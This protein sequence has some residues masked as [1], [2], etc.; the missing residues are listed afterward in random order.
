MH[1][2]KGL[3][4]QGADK[5]WALVLVQERGCRS[6]R[7]QPA[8][9]CSSLLSAAVVLVPKCHMQMF[10]RH[11]DLQ[12]WQAGGSGQVDVELPVGTKEDRTLEERKMREV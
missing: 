11:C 8:I 2:G 7:G 12:N 1:E 5:V 9:L 10:A 3:L 4:V 6:D